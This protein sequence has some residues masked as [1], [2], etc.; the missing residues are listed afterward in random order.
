MAKLFIVDDDIG[1]QKVYTILFE[2]NDYEV[3]VAKNSDELHLL[4]KEV[5]PDIILLDINLPGKSGFDIVK[6]MKGKDEYKD[7]QVILISSVY[8]D[9]NNLADGYKRGADGYIVRP[10]DNVELLSRMD[11]IK[12]HKKTLDELKESEKNLNKIISN[13]PDPIIITDSSGKIKFANQSAEAMFGK[14]GKEFIGADFGFPIAGKD[15]A[16]IDTFVVNGQSITAEMRAV[17]MEY[18]NEKSYIITLRDV[19]EKQNLINKLNEYSQSL[20]KINAVKDKMFS[21]ISHDLRSPY[22]QTLTIAEILETD[23]DTL[24]RQE[25]SNYS[26]ILIKVLTNQLRLVDDLLAW[27]KIQT[28]KYKIKMEKINANELVNELGELL[29]TNL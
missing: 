21:L 26:K 2:Q 14:E 11:A 16:E 22:Q 5:I 7:I 28:G 4:L 1:I 17:E 6:E 3:S 24:T 12:K 27:A 8:M 19:T 23:I 13:N 10:I 9:T 18:E 29:K 15:K 20:I 25:I